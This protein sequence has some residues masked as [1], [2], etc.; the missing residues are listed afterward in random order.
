MV[1]NLVPKHF[2]FVRFTRVQRE[3]TAGCRSPR[4][5]DFALCCRC[6]R[7]SSCFLIVACCCSANAP[8]TRKFREERSTHNAVSPH[9][10]PRHVSAE[11]L[12]SKGRLDAKLIDPPAFFASLWE[13]G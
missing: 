9:T 3:P 1:P 10:C 6:Y 5:P 8:S 7:G 11:E 12:L 4:P 2:S 13:V